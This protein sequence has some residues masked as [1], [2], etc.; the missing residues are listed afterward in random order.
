[1]PTGTVNLENHVQTQFIAPVTRLL[2]SV[3]NKLPVHM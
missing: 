2:T 1:M 3:T